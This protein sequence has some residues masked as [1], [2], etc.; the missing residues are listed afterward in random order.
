MAEI[1]N[2]G[3]EVVTLGAVKEGGEPDIANTLFQ[4]PVPHRQMS[5]RQAVKV[6]EVDVPGRSGK[7]KQAVG[8][9]DTEVTINLQLVDEED[10]AGT[11]TRSALDQFRELQ[12]AFRDRSDPVVEAGADT[13]S[14]SYAVPT[15]FSIQ[16]RLTDAC[17]LKTVL[18]RELDVSDLPGET[19]IEAVITFS[20]FEPVARQVERRKREA[21]EKKKAQAAAGVAAGYDAQASKAHD[22]EVGEESPL[23]KAFREGKADAMGGLP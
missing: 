20:E 5:I 17:G 14:F 4:F 23:A 10:R 11:V 19:S 6:D 15:I 8:Y 18:F 22:D 13:S 21:A 9:E 7:V 1:H 12:D 16:S 2:N 3:F